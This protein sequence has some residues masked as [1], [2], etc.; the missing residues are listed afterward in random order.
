M[1]NVFKI[2][3]DKDAHETYGALY[4]MT[5]SFKIPSNW[6]R[7]YVYYNSMENRHWKLMVNEHAGKFFDGTEAARFD[8][9]KH[10]AYISIAFRSHVDNLYLQILASPMWATHSLSVR[11]TPS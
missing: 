1:T 2:S 6:T 11:R 5:Y 9:S 8:F 7:A 10:E 3:I 4:P